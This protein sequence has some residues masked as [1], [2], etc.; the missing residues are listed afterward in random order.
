MSTNLATTKMSSKGQ[1]VIPETIRKNL[2]LENGC[3]FLVLGEKDAVILKTITAPSQKEFQGL[4]ANA[5]KAAKKAGLKPKD[6]ANAV[7]QARG[8]K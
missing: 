7:A 4:I 3:Q 1:V 8:K 5:R 2:G 6:I